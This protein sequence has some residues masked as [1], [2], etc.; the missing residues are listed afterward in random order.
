MH[1]FALATLTLALASA[2]LSAC[3]STLDSNK[4]G[5]SSNGAND[6]V[7]ESFLVSGTGSYNNI[8]FSFLSPTN[9]PF[10]SG[11]GY[12]FS[13]AYT[14][15]PSGLSTATTNLLGT[16]A[17][18]AGM[19]SFAPNLALTAGD[20]YYFYEDFQ[21]PA[22]QVYASFPE[23]G[24]DTFYYSYSSAVTF[25]DSSVTTDFMVQGTPV[26]TS[27]TP[28]PSSLALLGTGILGMAGVLKRRLA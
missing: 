6:F 11:T 22:H 17:S 13:S 9:T 8:T 21:F 18:G 4:G 24:S 14:G 1:R 7:G 10:A 2:P 19:Y 27:V 25:F 12:L 16:A 3:A 26:S 23:Q 15:T 28:E 5:T 20:T